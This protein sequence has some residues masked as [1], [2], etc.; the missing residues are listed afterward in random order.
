ML[1]K[2]GGFQNTIDWYNQNSESYAKHT[3]PNAPY[4]LIDE[5]LSLLPNNPKIIDVACGPGRDVEIF[6]QKGAHVVGIDI[7]KG[8]IRQAIIINPHLEFKT[9]N[10]LD[11]PFEKGSFDGLWAHN[12]LLHLESLDDVKRALVEFRRVLVESGVLYIQ[13]KKQE[14]DKKTEVVDD[15]LLGA[16]RFFRYFTKTEL[17]ALVEKSGFEILKIDYYDDP[18]KR[19]RTKKIYLFA[20]KI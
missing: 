11:L 4:D 19:Q 7:S 2:S 15:K 10:F 3:W 14:T 16:R 5:F 17:S 8:M 18:L 20:R 13:I 6:S 9:A 1:K 12:A